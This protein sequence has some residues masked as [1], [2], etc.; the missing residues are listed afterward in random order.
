[1]PRKESA[2]VIKKLTLSAEINSR[3]MKRLFVAVKINPDK[4]F[5]DQFRQLRENLRQEKIKWVEEFNIHV[6]LKF[7]GD[8][9]TK[10]IP[11]IERL[12]NSVAAQHKP[13][14]IKLSWLGV[15]GSRY[16]PRIIWTG[17]EPREDL[18]LLMQKIDQVLQ[19]VGFGPDRQNLVPHLTLG[20]IREIK[21][22][23]GFQKIMDQ[24]REISS[25]NMPVSEFLLYESI[26]RKEGPVYI[27]VKI[28]SLIK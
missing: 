3:N 5:I 23:P 8:T 25:V 15:F 28:F 11:E 26:L 16:D 6:T 9:E 14:S 24:F 4:A 7:L 19:S 1:M 13:F 2:K 20:R 18:I 12:L 10:K 27:P 17:I 21:D 22:K